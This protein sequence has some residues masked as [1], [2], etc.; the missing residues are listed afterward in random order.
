M[1]GIKKN[2]QAISLGTLGTLIDVY[3]VSHI[4]MFERVYS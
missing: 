4:M 3:I 2:L 1:R